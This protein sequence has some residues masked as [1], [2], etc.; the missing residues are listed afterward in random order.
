MESLNCIVIIT[1]ASLPSTMSLSI[2][3]SVAVLLHSL[4]YLSLADVALINQQDR[5]CCRR[6]S[7]LSRLPLTRRP[8]PSLSLPAPPS[9][10]TSSANRLCDSD[11]TSDLGLQLVHVDASHLNLD[12]KLAL[13]S[14]VSDIAL[15]LRSLA[16]ATDAART[17]SYV[18][19]CG[20]SLCV[21]LCVNFYG[22]FNLERG[23]ET[24]LV[25]EFLQAIYRD[26]LIAVHNLQKM[27]RQSDMLRNVDFTKSNWNIH[28]RVM[29]MWEPLYG[30]QKFA[31]TLELA[32]SDREGTTMWCTV[33]QLMMK[34]V[35]KKIQENGIYFIKDFF[36]TR[37][38]VRANQTKV[39][40]H[41]YKISF[42]QNT[43]IDDATDDD[44]P[45]ISFHTRAF[46]DIMSRNQINEIDLIDVIGLLVSKREIEEITIEGK[47]HRTLSI[48]LQDLE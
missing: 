2:E 17:T 3:C 48:I 32:V 41:K 15:A 8:T 46:H 47:T 16:D 33:P 4:A 39:S 11:L 18:G 12:P 20:S 28:V 10:L 23:M 21:N 19:E 34:T 44:F 29:R 22:R 9:V 40:T 14:K 5:I 35:K 37:N 42:Q 38:V 13:A 30:K 24:R 7:P 36:V 25:K 26:E 31:S 1:P 45:P 43:S 27:A 6:P